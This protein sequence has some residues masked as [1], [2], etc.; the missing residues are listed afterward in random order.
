MFENNIEIEY[1][2]ELS[3]IL[4]QQ[5]DP[6]TATAM[7]QYMKN[8]FPFWGIQKPVRSKLEKPFIKKVV[9][10]EDQGRHMID[11]LWKEPQREYQYIGLDI[12]DKLKRSWKKE[13]IQLL[14]KFITEKSWWDT[15]DYIASNACGT[16]FE[17]YPAQI[18][19]ICNQ[20]IISD[21]IWLV[22]SAILFQLKYGEKTD[23][24]RLF[25]YC[26][27]HIHSNEFFIQKAMGWALRE[28]GYRKNERV[29][30][31]LER[32]PFPALTVREGLKRSFQKLEKL[33]G[34][35]E[36]QN[37]PDSTR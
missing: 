19:S 6:E 8:L 28:Y 9:M 25:D 33:G 20:W 15:V 18:D 24:Q 37:E 34:K 29:V 4:S 23:E 26:L 2:S 3:Q 21:N 1:L 31:F 5:A 14:E 11:R 10:L 12:L 35:A 27:R 7:S 13:D 17:Q 16:F 30:A 36:N 22:R 32:H